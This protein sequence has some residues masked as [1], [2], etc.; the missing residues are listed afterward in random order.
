MTDITDADRL[1]AILADIEAPRA[2]RPER[3][4]LTIAGTARAPKPAPR[5]APVIPLRPV[6]HR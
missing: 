3:P 6:Q 1:H 4:V 2:G 5:L